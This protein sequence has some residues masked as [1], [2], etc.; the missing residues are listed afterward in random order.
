MIVSKSQASL[1]L[2]CCGSYH[3]DQP[4]GYWRIKTRVPIV[5]I[6]CIV[7][8]MMLTAVISRLRYKVKKPLYRTPG[9]CCHLQ[10]SSDS[11]RNRV[12]YN[13]HHIHTH[14][15]L[16]AIVSD[17]FSWYLPLTTDAIIVRPLPVFNINTLYVCLCVCLWTR[18]L[19]V[20]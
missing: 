1:P 17:T 4:L 20:G 11:M 13:I 7:D 15:C 5:P 14:T 16:A 6:R 9:S 19:S 10:T 18:L 2:L 3:L 12:K 8:S